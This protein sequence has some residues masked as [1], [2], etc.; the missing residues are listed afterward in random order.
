MSGTIS[1]S[2]SYLESLGPVY[3]CPK[4]CGG[5]LIPVY[6]SYEQQGQLKKE[7]E[8]SKCGKVVKGTPRQNNDNRKWALKREG[9][10]F[11]R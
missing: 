3:K 4:G 8:C 7:W 6:V 9:K 11:K 2:E 10:R 5:T 1:V